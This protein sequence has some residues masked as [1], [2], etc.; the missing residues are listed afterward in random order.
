MT[1]KTRTQEAHTE[2]LPQRRVLVLHGPNLNLLSSRDP[3]SG[4][5]L[6]LD[7]KLAERS[8]GDAALGWAEEAV[9]FQLVGVLGVALG[10][11]HVSRL[12][13]VTDVG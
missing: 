8:V 3:I 12:G 11:E 4:E 6:T 7:C 1:R 5:Q 10:Y 13:Q 2:S 9:A